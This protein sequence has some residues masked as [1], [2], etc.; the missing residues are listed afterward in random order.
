LSVQPAVKT[1][2]SDKPS[3]R[4]KIARRAALEFRDGMFANLGGGIPTMTEHFIPPGVNVHLQSENGILGMGSF[5]TKDE[6]NN[7]VAS[8]L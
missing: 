5:P 7:L 6:V 2:S 1:P 8:S 4:E 3:K